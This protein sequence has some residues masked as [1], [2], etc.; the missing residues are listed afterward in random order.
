MLLSENREGKTLL[1]EIVMCAM[2]NDGSPVQ[3]PE[4][5]GQ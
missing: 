2:F 4:Q 1:E 5:L 3:S